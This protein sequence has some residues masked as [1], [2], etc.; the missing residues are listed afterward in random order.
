MSINSITT[1]PFN[2]QSLGF[3][4]IRALISWLN[5][6]SLSGV[7]LEA[8]KYSEELSS[9]ISEQM[10]INLDGTGKNIVTDN[11]VPLP[12]K[13]TIEAYIGSSTVAF[14]VANS[15]PNANLT[16]EGNSFLQ[17]IGNTIKNFTDKTGISLP[18]LEPTLYFM[19]S[20]KLQVQVL[21]NAWLK[22][23]LVWFKDRDGTYIPV[24]IDSMKFDS[25]PTIANKVPISITLKEVIVYNGFIDYKTQLSNGGALVP[26]ITNP[27]SSYISLGGGTPNFVS[28]GPVP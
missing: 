11:I 4:G 26:D 13:W 24:G 14:A 20:L 15:P 12:R 21:R 16:P 6:P 1:I 19:P 5:M 27:A 8:Y 28:T 17:N 25:D 3:L 9:K 2:F 22:Y 10:I 18:G 7:R 23:K